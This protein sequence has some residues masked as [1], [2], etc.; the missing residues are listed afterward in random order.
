VRATAE[1]PKRRRAPAKKTA[2]AKGKADG[3]A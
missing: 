2:K 1:K 3:K